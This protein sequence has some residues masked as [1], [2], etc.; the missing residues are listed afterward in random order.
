MEPRFFTPALRRPGYIHCK[1]LRQELENV[2]MALFLDVQKWLRTHGKACPP[3]PH[4][5]S[6]APRLC[7]AEST[8]HVPRGAILM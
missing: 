6:D 2:S 8:V 3:A 7:S 5:A 1:S 4:C